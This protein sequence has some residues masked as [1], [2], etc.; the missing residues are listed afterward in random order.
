[1]QDF[2]TKVDNSP[3]PGGQLSAAAFNNLA[4]ENENA[5][6]RSGQTLSGASDT[7]LARSLFLHGVKSESF[8]DSGA[9]NAYVATPVS[10]TN[11]VLLPPDYANMDGAVIVFKASNANS[12]ASTV[13]IGQT[14]GTLLGAKAIVDQG[15]TALTAG[16]IVGNNYIQLRYD[17]SIGAGSWVLLPW[18]VS[19]SNIARFTASGTYIVPAGVTTIYVSGCAGGGGGGGG[20]SNNTGNAAGSGGSGGGAGQSI[21]RQLFTVTPGTIIAI[22][23]G[24]G[25]SGG[26]GGGQGSDSATNGTDGGNTVIGGLITLTGGLSGLR[27]QQGGAGVAVVGPAGG[28]G[29]PAGGWA[30]DGS[31]P[32]ASVDLGWPGLSGAGGSSKFGGGG[33]SVRA[34]KTAGGVGNSGDGFGS[35]G[36][37]GGS[38]YA[39]GGAGGNGGAGSGGFVLIEY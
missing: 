35:G 27:G 2:G 9:A 11:G 16:A 17:S 29:F 30:S 10:G 7:Q 21:I 6:A 23:I 13:N 37:G 36:G 26:G 1:M 32:T 18:A 20:G 33:Q 25:G 31:A 3:P 34:G 39:T 24:S 8:Q 14:T 12:G 28:A 15:G 22:T 38:V 19:A 5:V 4:T